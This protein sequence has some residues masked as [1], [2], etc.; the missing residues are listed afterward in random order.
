[1]SKMSHSE[2]DLEHLEGSF[3]SLGWEE[4]EIKIAINTIQRNP[5]KFTVV[6]PEHYKKE[7]ELHAKNTCEY[8][9][10]L[11][12]GDKDY[13][14]CYTHCYNQYL[15]DAYNNSKGIDVDAPNGGQAR[16]PTTP[17]A[18][19]SFLASIYG[20]TNNPYAKIINLYKKNPDDSKKRN[21]DK[22][23]ASLKAAGMTFAHLY[24]K[25]V[26]ELNNRRGEIVPDVAHEIKATSYEFLKEMAQKTTEERDAKVRE[27]GHHNFI[28]QILLTV[29]L[30]VI[31]PIFNMDFNNILKLTKRKCANLPSSVYNDRVWLDKFA[32]SLEYIIR[33]DMKEINIS[34]MIIDTFTN[35][36]LVQKELGDITIKTTPS[37]LKDEKHH[38]LAKE[39]VTTIFDTKELKKL[40]FEKIVKEGQKTVAKMPV[41]AP[42]PAKKTT[43]KVP[44]KTLP[45]QGTETDVFGVEGMKITRPD[46]K[47][48]VWYP[49]K[50]LVD[51]QGVWA[52]KDDIV[53]IGDE[54][55]I[56]DLTAHY[57]NYERTWKKNPKK[58]HPLVIRGRVWS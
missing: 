3:R 14:K 52:H 28:R 19:A 24:L 55:F 46:A 44:P 21:G 30:K 1:M 35:L 40:E 57:D 7:A 8:K 26:G 53:E 33:K 48:A 32:K 50:E 5:K 22:F 10:N 15:V 20:G 34:N 11:R 2:K 31:E 39:L 56:K 13:A 6:M 23:K 18:E 58:K 43:P 17:R 54:K 16:N 41:V 12:K 29:V 49:L 42:V 38:N 45:Q 47:K 27:I 36:E 51:V 37:D 4:P 25:Y 9:H